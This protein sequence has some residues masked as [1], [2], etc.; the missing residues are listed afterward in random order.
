[1]YLYIPTQNNRARSNCYYNAT[2]PYWMF[3]VNLFDVAAIQNKR[4]V[5]VEGWAAIMQCG[6]V[7]LRDLIH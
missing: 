7:R 3:C 2:D 1:M 6:V 4:H 5:C